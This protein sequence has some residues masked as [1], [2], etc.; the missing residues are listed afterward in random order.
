METRSFQYT[1]AKSNK[2]W[3]ITLEDSSHT[4]SYGRIGT[5]G[6]TESKTFP[7]PEQAKQS[8]EKLIQQKLSKGYVEVNQDTELLVESTAQEIAEV[9]DTKVSR[10]EV[11][12]TE[13]L[14]VTRVLNLNPEDWRFCSWRQRNPLARPE[15]KA[16]N[17]EEAINYLSD[18]KYIKHDYLD[19]NTVSVSVSLSHEE[20]NFWL[21][22]MTHKG[23]YRC[24]LPIP[25]SKLLLDVSKVSFTNESSLN[26]I[27][28]GMIRC[29]SAVYDK[30]TPKLILPTS[31]LF[32]VV[33]T[34]IAL[35]KIASFSEAE[36]L[37]YA[38]FIWNSDLSYQDRIE[39]SLGKSDSQ[40]VI[41]HAKEELING[42]RGSASK[43]LE[44]L[45]NG[46][47]KHLLHYLSDAESTLR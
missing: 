30:I 40:W 39:Q 23:A 12:S 45:L 43:I 34:I 21:F 16:F 4:V 47:E 7:T 15:I 18:I 46:F 17:K 8:Y 25:V 33:E 6:K 13:K 5:S 3:T 10:A 11:K 26:E 20:A 28:P 32:G 24:R 36:A 44:T 22:V 19:S 42:V 2:F 14:E 35:D 38:Y 9:E 37:E 31:S 27:I 41:D 29:Q 1:D